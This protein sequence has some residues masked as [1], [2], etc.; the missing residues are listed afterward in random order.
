MTCS[1]KF[2]VCKRHFWWC[3]IWRHP[4]V[5]MLKCWAKF[6]NGSLSLRMICA[7]NYE[8][9]FKFVKVMPRILRASFFPNMVYIYI[10]HMSDI[11]PCQTWQAVLASSHAEADIHAVWEWGAMLVRQHSAGVNITKLLAGA[12]RIQCQ[13]SSIYTTG[14]KLNWI[15]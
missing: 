1:D 15:C 11:T 9:V 4:H 12:V 6:S 10:I 2:F 14:L 13:D 3:Q 5:V 7:K 8:A